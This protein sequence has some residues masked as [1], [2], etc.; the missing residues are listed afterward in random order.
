MNPP[1]TENRFIK[2]QEVY[3]LT[4]KTSRLQLKDILILMLDCPKAE[5]EWKSLKQFQSKA[6]TLQI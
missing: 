1:Y 6:Y 4:Y 5:K 2:S 3:N